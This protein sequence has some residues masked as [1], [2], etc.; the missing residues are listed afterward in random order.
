MMGVIISK[1]INLYTDSVLWPVICIGHGQIYN[2]IV[3]LHAFITIFHCC[4]KE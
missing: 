1:T 2:S 3:T 4:D